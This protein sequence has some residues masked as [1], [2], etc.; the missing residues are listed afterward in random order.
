MTVTSEAA[1]DTAAVAKMKHPATTPECV[2][3][4]LVGR[5]VEQARAAGLQLTGRRA[6]ANS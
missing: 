1:V 3:A 6:A 2:D 4:E 5:L